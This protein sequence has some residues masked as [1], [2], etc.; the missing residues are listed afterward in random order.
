MVI[1]KD[2]IIAVLATFCLTSALFIVIPTK[3]SSNSLPYDP[4]VDLNGDGTIDIYD[5]TWAAELYDTSGNPTRSVNV[6]NWP[7]WWL[8]GN[9]NVTNLPLDEQGNLKVSVKDGTNLT[10]KK[11]LERIVILDTFSYGTSGICLAKPSLGSTTDYFWFLFEP[12]SEF[13]NV[14]EIYINVIWR[15][16]ASGTAL[17]PHSLYLV[18]RNLTNPIEFELFQLGSGIFPS[19]EARNS[20]FQISKDE[21][22]FNFNYVYEGM[23]NIEIDRTD[24]YGNWVYIYKLE[25]FIEYNYLG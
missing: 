17:Q 11:G 12:K 19:T 6:T 10:M 8:S 15:A 3:G 16:E 18:F 25:L 24:S 23:N 1:K 2:L 14:T 7:A 21:P 5:I 9:V 22:T 13:I 4:W 20:D